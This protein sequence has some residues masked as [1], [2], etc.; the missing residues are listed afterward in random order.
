MP[1][2][3]PKAIA[4]CDDME[5]LEKFKG[6]GEIDAAKAEELIRKA[7]PLHID[8]SFTC[9][10]TGDD[11]RC[12][13][14]LQVLKNF[15]TPS[16][17]LVRG[18]EHCKDCIYDIKEEPPVRHLSFK[19]SNFKLEDFHSAMAKGKPYINP[20]I[21]ESTG[22]ID[23]Q[24]LKELYSKL[25]ASA[26]DMRTQD[27]YAVKNIIIDSRTYMLHRQERACIDG[28]PALVLGLTTP[29]YRNIR[30]LV[31]DETYPNTLILQDPFIS[32][33]NK[34]RNRIHFILQFDSKHNSA[35]KECSNAITK[36]SKK[37]NGTPQTEHM[38]NNTIFLIETVWERIKSKELLKSFGCEMAFR[39]VITN[40]KQFTQLDGTTSAEDP[41]QLYDR[42]SAMENQNTNTETKEEVQSPES[43]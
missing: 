23:A 29:L 5:F 43:E 28:H 25:T 2:V 15:D 18:S 19:L 1:S 11:V 21:P 30:A 24:N 27:D 33:K 36:I 12:T 10:G 35:F 39:G 20:V 41:R 14:Q 42:T 32:L 3:S 34:Q 38:T 22:L 16:F 17:I 4:V 31:A 26:L 37:Q 8:I 7:K 9:A 13:A 40:K 6:T